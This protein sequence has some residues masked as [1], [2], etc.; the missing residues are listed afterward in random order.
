MRMSFAHILLLICAPLAALGPA[1]AGL[2]DAEVRKVEAAP[3]PDAALPLDVGFI[4]EA[5]RAVTLRTAIG[6]L[7]TVLVFADYTCR[8]L[9]GP[10]LEFTTSGL[11]K[12]GLKPGADYRLVAIGI[13]PKD[14][15]AAAQAMRVRHIDSGSS[16]NAAA[17]FLTG[18]EAA[19]RAVAQAAGLHYYYDAEH[20][21]YAHPAAVYVVGANGRVRRVLSPL[22]L[23]GA[24]LRLAVVDAGRGS[25]GTLADRIHLLCY[26]YDPVKGVYTERISSLL[27]FAA[28]ITLVVLLSGISLMA[29]RDR[30]SLPP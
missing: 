20:D 12:T 14:K 29:L 30:R 24:D 9:C 10:I 23:D 27:A 25:V 4:D 22:G 26:G 6:G 13:D 16:I 7:P 1:R 17:V 18:G 5:G 3:A 28:G 15:P 11:A 21:Q 8:T 2:V 19:V